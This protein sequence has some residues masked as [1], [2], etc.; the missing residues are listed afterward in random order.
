MISGMI[1][2]NYIPVNERVTR[3][4]VLH[5]I[6]TPSNPYMVKN[7]EYLQVIIRKRFP[8][9]QFETHAVESAC[10]ISEIDHCCRD[11]L[12]RHA[13]D[14]WVLNA[15]GGTKLM[16]A[17]AIDCFREEDKR[18]YYVDTA[19][20]QILEIASDWSTI[21]HPF[22][23]SI[24]VDDYFG[25]HGHVIAHGKP[26]TKQEKHIF[27][28][29]KKLDWK[30]WPSVTWKLLDGKGDFAEYDMIAIQGYRVSIFECK[31][32]T[33]NQHNKKV[34]RENAKRIKDSILIDLYKLSA[35]KRSFGGPFGNTYWIKSGKTPV[36]EINLERIREFDIRLIEGRDIQKLSKVPEQFG[37]P[38]LKKTA[39]NNKN[40]VPTTA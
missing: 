37:L 19:R 32:L 31:R 30:I 34:W 39:Q 9:I 14:D 3:P 26:E 10:N 15:T 4:D 25:L 7:W 27:N 8:K 5:A 38:R 24:H 36:S 2:P 28:Q 21:A 6:L 12:E 13:G 22:Q 29:L 20:D 18:V 40:S 11:L 35:A 16:S 33:I 1:L 23:G 17:P